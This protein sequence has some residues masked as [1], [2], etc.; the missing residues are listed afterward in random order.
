[1]FMCISAMCHVLLYTYSVL[2]MFSEQILLTITQHLTTVLLDW[3]R[4]QRVGTFFMDRN[5]LMRK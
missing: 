2:H 4:A 5:E 3:I 1:M